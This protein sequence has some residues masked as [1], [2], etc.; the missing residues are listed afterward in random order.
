MRCS[1][2]PT[3][4]W[5]ALL[6]YEQ[7]RRRPPLLL[8]LLL[9]TPRRVEGGRATAGE[10]SRC[11]YDRGF[12]I[13]R[14]TRVHSPSFYSFIVVRQRL[15]IPGGIRLS[16]GSYT[17]LPLEDGSTRIE[18]ETRYLGFQRPRWLW[19]QIESAVCHAFHRHILRA[20]RDRVAGQATFADVDREAHRAPAAT[21]NPP[22]RIV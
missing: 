11:V 4:V 9:P 15:E 14:T 7:I 16:G 21:P 6:F 22:L 2:T 18:V 8:R 1:A 5:D 17:L 10:E 13:K 19:R 12:L 20:I 3:R